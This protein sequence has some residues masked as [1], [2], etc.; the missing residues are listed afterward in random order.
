MVYSGWDPLGRLAPALVLGVV[1][2]ARAF[3][4]LEQSIRTGLSRPFVR[5]ARARG[6]SLAGIV[7]GHALRAELPGLLSLAALAVAHLL[8]GAVVVEAAFGYPGLGSLALEAVMERDPHL[9]V[10]TLG[11]VAATVVGANLAA[12]GAASLAHSSSER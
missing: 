6:R 2:G 4:P 1:E 12:D 7:F 8:T 10:T 11:V 5:A 9:L 3:P